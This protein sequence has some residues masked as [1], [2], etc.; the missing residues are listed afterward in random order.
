[1][2][3]SGT[4]AAPTVT[5]VNPGTVVAGGLVT[6]TGTALDRVTHV[7]VNGSP[8]DI[9]A[10]ATATSLTFATRSYTTTGVIQVRAGSLSA[11]GPSLTVTRP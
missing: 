6:I 10:G 7:T 9:Q 3:A 11:N 4:V 2:N 5:G 8:V 1:M